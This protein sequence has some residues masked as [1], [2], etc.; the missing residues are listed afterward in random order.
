MAGIVIVG[1]G[2]CGV[3]AAHGAREAGFEG[4]IT[5]I[6][7]DPELP[8]ERPPLSKWEG[9]EPRLQPIFANDWYAANDIDLRR[10]KRVTAIDR[11]TQTV[12][13]SAG[14]T[15]SYA[16]LL[17]ATGA[18]PRR[19]PP[20]ALL[21]VKPHYLR[22]HSDARDLARRIGDG[23]DVLIV[24]GGFV[25]LELAASLAARKAF[26]HVIEAQDRILARAVPPEISRRVHDLHVERGVTIHTATTITAV[27]DNVARLS[28]G[29]S[30][31]AEHVIIGIGSVPNTDLATDAGLSVDN[32]IAVN[33][34]FA[35]QAPNIFA[36]GD[37][38]NVPVADGG[39]ARFESWQVAGEQGRRAGQAMA[40]VAPEPA[41]PPWFWSDQFDHCLQVVGLQSAGTQ[42]T[43][44]PLP[45]GGIIAIETRAGGQITFAAG[46]APGNAAG[47]DI[48]VLQKLME[49]G[50]AGDPAVLADP[51]T[52]LKTI[53]RQR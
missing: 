33:D 40:G 44:R 41:Q 1:A 32:G 6:G 36:A 35:T 9:A 53:L 4:Q 38:C 42:N 45:D 51:G 25:G 37:C 19:L 34:R 47:R 26:V 12:T 22:T 52:P 46:F 13:L 16:K 24:G 30:V 10:G 31:R 20:E 21:F 17:L 14:E 18:A 23:A 29:Q 39:R 48:K 50:I 28:N 3:S 27:K 43:L 2:Y 15:L 11:A 7:D 5:L 49:A 8:Y